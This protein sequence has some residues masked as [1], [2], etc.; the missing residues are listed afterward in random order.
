[1]SDQTD[2][3]SDTIELVEDSEPD[4]QLPAEPEKQVQTKQPAP[5]QPKRTPAPQKKSLNRFGFWHFLALAIFIFGTWAF[6]NRPV[7]AFV[8]GVKLKSFDRKFQANEV[9][10]LY[11]SLHPEEVFTPYSLTHDLISYPRGRT[12]IFGRIKMDDKRFQH[13]PIGASEGL[14][15]NHGYFM[16]IADPKRPVEFI[17][18]GYMPVVIDLPS[19]DL[20]GELNW[21]GE[22]DMPRV[23]STTGGTIKGRLITP[24]ADN[25]GPVQI[26]V[27]PLA[28]KAIRQPA[29]SLHRSDIEHWV[30]VPV[31]A[32]FEI[33]GCAPYRYD[34]FAS[35]PE[36]LHVTKEIEFKPGQTVDLGDIVLQPAPQML[37]EYRTCL[38]GVF[39]NEPLKRLSVGG[40]A[41]TAYFDN[42]GNLPDLVKHLDF[43][44]GADLLDGID[45]HF[46]W[47]QQ[48]PAT[49]CDLGELKEIPATLDATKLKMTDSHKQKLQLG[50]VYATKAHSDGWL[51][52]RMTRK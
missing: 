41:P 14:A 27:S 46:Q 18:H 31:N 34:F 40:E 4:K 7:P 5:E 10:S 19:M 23:S 35:A 16:A 38:H 24:S 50:H 9:M 39:K 12:V 52:W 44:L 29:G 42:M 51:L 21:I 45:W 25:Y 1:M 26:L 48:I 49:I 20:K 8:E 32:P 3:K 13:F 30:G 2:V 28:S 33:T 47:F 22:F 6:V 11:P 37:M 36:Y 43:S 15:W 17:V